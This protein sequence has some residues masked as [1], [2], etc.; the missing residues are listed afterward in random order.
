MLCARRQRAS[1]IDDFPA[2]QHRQWPRP[3]YY[4]FIAKGFEVRD[5]KLGEHLGLNL[6]LREDKG[7]ARLSSLSSIVSSRCR[8]G[9]RQKVERNSTVRLEKRR[10]L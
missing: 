10:E 9:G 5:V 8:F 1:G 2:G 6:N 7:L 3:Q 4:S